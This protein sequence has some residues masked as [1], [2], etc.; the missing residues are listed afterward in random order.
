MYSLLFSVGMFESYA[1]DFFFFFLYNVS[2]D[3]FTR[4][5]DLLTYMPLG[6][7]A[8]LGLHGYAGFFL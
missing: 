6:L 4:F 1:L 3:H 5:H 7:M 8:V 2:L